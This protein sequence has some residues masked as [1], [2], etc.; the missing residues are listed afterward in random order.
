MRSLSMIVATGLALGL[1]AA[2]HAEWY[3]GADLGASWLPDQKVDFNNGT[4]YKADHQVGPVG[5]AQFGYDFGGLK[6]EGE[7]GARTN[8][9]DKL[10]NRATA[11]GRN[12]ASGST[13]V[14]S[15]MGN[16][17]YDFNATGALHPF[18]GAG[19]GPAYV[20]INPVTDSDGARVY[21][22]EDWRFAY[23]GFAGVGY[24]IDANWTLKGQYRYFATLDGDVSMSG[25]G[26]GGDTEYKSHEVLIGLTYRF[27]APQAAAVAAATPAPAKTAA[28]APAPVVQ[29]FMV[30]FD[31]DKAVLT[32]E[33]QT[34][35]NKAAVAFKNGKKPRIDLTGHADRAGTEAYN[36]KLSKRRADAVRAALVRLGVP[37]AEIAVAAKGESAPLVATPDGV[38]EPQNRRVEIVLP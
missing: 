22:G 36:M 5:L 26:V 2:A 17:I 16:A 33:A 18:L 24:D 27:G 4:H 10:K 9:I 20:D 12:G 35:L 6:L 8:D 31:F 19:I 14:Y 30:F 29:N 1:P 23:Q 28:P 7:F 15:L 25:S 34:I 21:S 38:R 32:P 3:A 37:A 11:S 13:T